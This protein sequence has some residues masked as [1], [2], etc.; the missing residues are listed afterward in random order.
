[1]PLQQ[2]VGQSRQP[3]GVPRGPVLGEHV[4]GVPQVKIP[5]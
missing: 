1:V 3:R 4:D 5:G 2:G